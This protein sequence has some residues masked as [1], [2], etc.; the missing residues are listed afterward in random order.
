VSEPRPVVIVGTGPAGVSAALALRARGVPVHLLEAG[1]GAVTLPPAGNY[2]DLRRH[3]AAQWRWQVGEGGESLRAPAQAS[4]KLRVPGLRSIFEGFGERNRIDAAPG[5]HLVGAMAPGGLSNAW[6]CGVARF[7]GEELGALQGVRDE[8]L[9]SYATV[10]TRMGL[11]GA[12]D[13][14]LRDYFGLDDWS[15]PALPLDALHGH[16]WQRH[17]QR[18]GVLRLGRARVAVLGSARAGRS[19]CDLSGLCLWGCPGRATWSAALDLE[20]LRRDPGVTLELDARVEQLRADGEGGWWLAVDG[21]AGL[22]QLR[23]RRVLLA[24]G[25][26]ATTRLAWAALAQPP[27]ELRLQSNPMAAFLLA[28]PRFLGAAR[29][30]AFGLAQLSFVIESGAAGPGFGNLF[31]TAGLPVSEFLQHLPL[32]RR[33]GLPLLRALLPATVVGNLFLPGA[34]SSHRLRLDG[35]GRMRVEPGQAPGL[36]AALEG[37]R[38]TL[39][40]GFRRLGGWMLPGSFVPGAPGAD[41]HY[42][43][44]L[45][46]ATDP[47]P[48]QCHP[49]GQLAGLPGVHVIDGA[50]LPV[51]PAK[52]HTLTLMANADR[53]A[54]LVPA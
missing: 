49:D 40:S 54:R 3:D 30:P 18:P 9:A 15:G 27:A 28:L 23:A 2:L 42:A 11:S 7:D 14:G 17:R 34:L 24:T 48:H 41:L 33:A 35:G 36:E 21:R 45:P 8:L 37:A 32:R 25:T 53:I 46:H 1:T 16:L 22:R 10:A 52:A 50:S 13:D 12:S 20:Q 38:T 39:A 47:A 51:L 5:F 6:G 19:A 31:S 43:C 44:T 4:P 26:L 29:E